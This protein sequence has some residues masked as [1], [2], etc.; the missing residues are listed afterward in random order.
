MPR[1]QRRFVAA[2]GLAT[3]LQVRLIKVGLPTGQ[4]E[5]LATSFLDSQV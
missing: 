4:L 5:V 1:A 3:S 2:Q